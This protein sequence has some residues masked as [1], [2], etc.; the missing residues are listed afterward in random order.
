[1]KYSHNYIGPLDEKLSHKASAYFTHLMGASKDVRYSVPESFLALP[2]DTAQ[3]EY[4]KKT[5][6]PFISKHLKYV[7][8]AGI[9]GS[10]LGAR[11]IQKAFAYEHDHLQKAHIIFL[12]NC[13][14]SFIRI[15]HGLVETLTN[16]E[17]FVFV[18]ISKSGK[19]LETA[20]N[21]DVLTKILEEKFGDVDKRIIFVTDEDSELYKF[22]NKRS[23]STI[24]I[25]HIVGGRFSVF[26]SAG[27]VPL[28]LAGFSVDFLLSGA[29][30]AM[31]MKTHGMPSVLVSALYALRE[32]LHGKAVR[33][34]FVFSPC[35]EDLGK[36]YRQLSAESLGKHVKGLPTPVGFIPTVSVGTE[37]LHSIGQRYFGGFSNFFTTFLHVSQNGESQYSSGTFAQKFSSIPSRDVRRVSSALC[38][39]VK[40][41][42][43]DK[44]ISFDECVLEKISLE[45]LGCFMQ[46]KMM[47]TLI[48][49]HL[50][51]INVFD[52]PDVEGY[53]I[54]AKERLV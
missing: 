30:E 27:L 46:F 22:G 51:G 36:W 40:D 41:S 24:I 16:I 8:V 26:S 39:S 11:A 13:D 25:P 14:E 29:R 21:A 5:L 28:I 48:I 34:T 20:V 47:E 3:L 7:F 53:K 43:R 50:A 17:D 31:S 15:A 12:E 44:K 10:S 23:I 54:K 35:L 9:G 37:D 38:E 4:I 6:K 19:T 32:S 1:M 49:G 2:Y 33:D 18:Y 42:Y 45:E 52:Q